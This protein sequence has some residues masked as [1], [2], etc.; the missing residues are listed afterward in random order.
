MCYISPQLREITSSSCSEV[1][2]Y[3][4]EVCRDALTSL[5]M[6]F[7]GVTSAP[8]ALTIPSL[9]DQQTAER[10]LRNR[11]SHL[12][13]PPPPECREAI[14]PYLCLSV[15]QLCDSNNQLHSVVREDCL[16]LREDV[17][18]EQWSQVEAF[19]TVCEDLPDTTEEC[20]GNFF[21]L[22]AWL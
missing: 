12:H 10:D 21:T 6:C 14:L 13:P 22:T 1:E 18:A 2:P 8:P 4:G 17:C 15:F 16:A 20:L 7:S 9:V 5:Q 11:I 19:L 3:S